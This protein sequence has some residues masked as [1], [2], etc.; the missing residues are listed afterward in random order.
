MG[1]PNYRLLDRDYLEEAKA[2]SE[3]LERLYHVGQK[4][5]WDGK[6]LLAGLLQKHGGVHLARDKRQALANIFSLILWGEL[7]AWNISADLALQLEDPS[8]K[9]AAT[10]QAFDEAR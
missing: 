10:G 5:A 2:K 7:A 6:E 4:Q 3:R 1:W 8:A 9:M